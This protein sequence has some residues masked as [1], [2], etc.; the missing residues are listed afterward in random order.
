MRL[1][2]ALFMIAGVLAIVLAPG[3]GAG[4]GG[5]SKTDT[6]FN[7]INDLRNS[8]G[9]TALTHDPSLKAVAQAYS[10]MWSV[11]KPTVPPPHYQPDVDGTTLN[12]RLTNGGV[13]FT[14]CDETGCV[15]YT[16]STP[17]AASGY[18]NQS[19]LLNP[20]FTRVGVGYDNYFCD[21]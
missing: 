6:L 11:I 21:M 13:S 9:V 15:D 2:L 3:C 19:K 8:S 4:G 10:E 18:M 1:F 7:M 20:A 12:S 5:G 16:S 14:S 17:Q